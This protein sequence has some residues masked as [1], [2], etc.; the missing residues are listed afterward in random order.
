[1]SVNVEGLVEKYVALRDKKSEYKAEYDAKVA[2]IDS[3]LARVE[4]VLL[5]H[6]Q[7]TG[8]ESVR[9][10]AG[11]AYKSS[12]TSATVADWDSFFAFVQDTGSY[13]MLEHRC[14]K[15]AV[16]EYKQA[17]E[18]LPPGLNWSEEVTVGVRRGK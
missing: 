8:A 14:S 12:R 2:K 18:D 7:D 1:M 5:T 13:H 6:F 15:R 10:S 11:T 16:E 4:G 3:L 9:T 17:N